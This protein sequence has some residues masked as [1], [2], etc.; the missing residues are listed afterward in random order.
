[1]GRFRIVLCGT[2]FCCIALYSIVG[3]FG[4]AE[5]GDSIEGNILLN[6]PASSPLVNT[7]RGCMTVT[8]L[9]SYPLMNFVNRKGID[10]LIERIF[11][12]Y[13]PDMYPEDWKL[14][15]SGK[16]YWMRT[17]LVSFILMGCAW[18]IAIILP[19]IQLIFGLAGSILIPITMF[20]V[21]CIL[22]WKIPNN[23]IFFGKIIPLLVIIFGSIIGILGTIATVYD[24]VEFFKDSTSE[25]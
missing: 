13:S 7:A 20:I 17:I 14:Q 2:L 15:P 6:Y 16:Y 25:N 22:F 10:Y 12:V 5:F 21:P 8:A 4:Y 11:S 24:V 9:F 3:I 18:I 1:M 23:S 19:E